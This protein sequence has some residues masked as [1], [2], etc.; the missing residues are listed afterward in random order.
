MAEKDVGPGSGLDPNSIKI[1]F[2]DGTS[3]VYAKVSGEVTSEKVLQRI[4]K[5]FPS[6]EV[7]KIIGTGVHW[8]DYEALAKIF[9]GEVSVDEKQK[10]ALA[11]ALARLSP[12]NKADEKLPLDNPF[13]IFDESKIH[14]AFKIRKEEQARLND[15]WWES[16]RSAY[17]RGL[18]SMLGGLVALWVFSLA[19]GWIVRGFLGIPLKKDLKQ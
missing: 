17:G 1:F 15:K 16:W 18:A 2:T 19:M 11:N 13:D 3:H 14:A 4:S 5:D 9:G 8:V 10:I 12:K 6:K 7:A